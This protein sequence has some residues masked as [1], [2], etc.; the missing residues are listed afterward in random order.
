[1]IDSDRRPVSNRRPLRSLWLSQITV[2]FK[3]ILKSVS[4]PNSHIYGRF[5][6]IK[7]T[8]IS[9]RRSV[10]V[11]TLSHDGCGSSL[12]IIC[13]A[14]YIKWMQSVKV[15]GIIH[16]RVVYKKAHQRPSYLSKFE[17]KIKYDIKWRRKSKIQNGSAVDAFK[18]F[19]CRFPC[20]IECLIS[21]YT[22]ILLF[23]YYHN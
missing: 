1:M 22:K 5:I 11:F 16:T 19:L 18:Q 17:S 4:F 7:S 10:C 9:E 6:A 15:P 20:S 3:G 8:S 12:Y 23:T 13:I 21:V 2:R 14:Y